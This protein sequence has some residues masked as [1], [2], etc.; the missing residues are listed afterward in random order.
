M[1]LPQNILLLFGKKNINMKNKKLFILIAIMCII[2]VFDLITALM[3]NLAFEANPI[4]WKFNSVNLFIILKLVFI[5]G[6]AVLIYKSSFNKNNF[7]RFFY[8][9]ILIYMIFIQSYGLWQNI[10]VMSQV[11]TLVANGANINDLIPTVEQKQNFFINITKYFYIYPMILSLFSFFVYDKIML[12]N[13][14]NE[15]TA[16]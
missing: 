2:G 8:A 4:I 9:F 10:E 11:K 3:G 7:V 15:N 5:S 6:L 14:K 12:K 13:N 1:Q 16:K